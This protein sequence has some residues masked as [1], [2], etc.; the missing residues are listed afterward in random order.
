M[1]PHTNPQSWSRCPPQPSPP[2]PGSMFLCYISYKRQHGSAC[3]IVRCGV[4]SSGICVVLWSSCVL[5]SR[6]VSSPVDWLPLSGV[7]TLQ[8][9]YHESR[10]TNKVWF[11]RL[12]SSLVVC[13]VKAPQQ[14]HLCKPW[15]Y[16][17]KSPNTLLRDM[18]RTDKV[19]RDVWR[20][21][22]SEKGFVCTHALGMSIARY[23]SHGHG[24]RSPGRQEINLGEL[25]GNQ[26]ARPLVN[27]LQ[28]CNKSSQKM[29]NKVHPNVKMRQTTKIQKRTGPG[30]MA[31]TPRASTG[32]SMYYRCS[33]ILIC[34]DNL[35]M[36]G[37]FL[38][39]SLPPPDNRR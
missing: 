18:G 9:K 19:L 2:I 11:T 36:I 27:S 35:S 15:K 34:Q 25:S 6:Y 26:V 3:V 16:E 22:V 28:T 32:D 1:H 29:W 13:A 21:K 37:T 12:H 14:V 5:L 30:R 17:I 24:F 39:S 10:Y 31:E 7:D 23:F 33:I 8:T 38:I 20:H 4:Q